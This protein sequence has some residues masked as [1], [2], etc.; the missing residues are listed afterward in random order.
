MADIGVVHASIDAGGGAE[1]V[2]AHAVAALA[3]AGHRMTLYTTD[4][5]DLAAL[6]ERYD[7]AIPN[8]VETRVVASPVLDAVDWAAVA[9]APLGVSDFPLL[10]KTAFER[11]VARR[12]QSEHDALV[13]THG[14]FAIGDAVEYVHFPYFSADAMR[15]YDTRFEESLYPPYHRVCRAL[16][17]RDSEN[18]VR[19]LT[20]SEWTASVVN[21]MLGRDAEV[22]YPP[23]DTAAFDPPP[24]DDMESGFVSLGRLHPLKRQH[25]LIELVD[26]VRE[27]GVETHLHIVGPTGDEAYTERLHELAASR[28]YVT[29][30]GRLP[31]EDVVSLLESHRYGLHARRFEHYG[32]AVAEMVAAGSLPFVHDSGG[33][34]EVVGEIDGLLYDDREDATEKLLEAL[35]SPDRQQRLRN[36]LANR[37][38]PGG[39][40]QF[41]DGLVATVES[42]LDR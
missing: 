32:I 2:G 39:R 30:D 34:R 13:C 1:A 26:A 42:H 23:V 24:W 35:R 20:N 4:T 28:P 14:E 11:L 22:L 9:A 40:E 25:E 16:K 8:A 29:L 12:Y 3:D 41:R 18:G 19:T 5:L 21:E 17:R 36:E 15:R 33:Q 10:R 27:A 6:S 7:A 31:R 38:Q 37:G